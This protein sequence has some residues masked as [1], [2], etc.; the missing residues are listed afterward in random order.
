MRSVYRC[1]DFDG[2]GVIILNRKYTSTPSCY[3][4]FVKHLGSVYELLCPQ[5]LKGNS[6]STRGTV[7]SPENCR[8]LVLLPALKEDMEDASS[9]KSVP[10]PVLTSKILVR[11]KMDQNP[12][13]TQWPT[14]PVSHLEG[15]TGGLNFKTGALDLRYHPLQW[16]C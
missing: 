13:G 6:R 16:A 7:S 8:A 5:V 10:L 15:L 14:F 9:C 2:I 12:R 3:F 11:F 1:C 4:K